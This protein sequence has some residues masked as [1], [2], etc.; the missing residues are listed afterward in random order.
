M[1]KISSIAASGLQ[2]KPN[3]ATYS[4]QE[5]FSLSTSR[6][7]NVEGQSFDIS[8]TSAN[9][10]DGRQKD[11]TITGVDSSD[12][13]NIDLSG[14]FVIENNID[15]TI[16]NTSVDASV[17]GVELFSLTL[18]DGSASV[19]VEI[20]DPTFTLSSDKSVVNEGESFTITLGTQGLS[21]GAQIAYTITGISSSDID[22]AALTGDFTINDNAASITFTVTDDGLSDPDETFLLSLDN[23]FDNISVIFREPTF[24]LSRSLSS[25]N[26]G[27]SFDITLT[28]TYI[29]DGTTFP[30]TVTGL[31]SADLTSGSITGNFVISSN[32]ATVSFIIAEDQLTE[33]VETF[34][35]SL[36]NG[37]ATIA[38]SIQ[39]TS[40][41]RTYALSSGVPTLNE[42]GVTT[43]TLETTNTP[44]GTLV[45]YTITG[46]SL[47]DIT[48]PSSLT[49]NFEI[50]N[51]IDAFN[52]FIR[53]DFL[54]EGPETIRIALDNDEAEV[55]I[56]IVDTSLTV[57]YQL[58]RS[59]TAVAEGGSFSIS[60][61]HSDI[62][63]GTVEP[64]TITGV[65]SAD[66]N[67]QSLTG[68]FT[69]NNNIA[70]V[71]FTVT[72][73][74]LTE[75]NET[76]TLTCDNIDIG[77][78]NLSISVTIVDTS[79]TPSYSLVATTGPVDEGD[80]IFVTLN[81]QNVASGTNIAYAVSGISADD[82]S[83]GSLSGNFNIQNN[84]ST[85][86]W[87]F[88]E[89]YATEGTETF[90]L[91]LTGIAGTPSV[92]VAIN[93]TT[94][95]GDLE[96]AVAS[97]TGFSQWYSISIDIS[98][99][100]FAV[101]D[102]GYNNGKGRVYMGR[103][104]D[105]TIFRTIDSPDIAGGTNRPAFGAG[106]TIQNNY[107]HV[108]SPTERSGP[109]GVP[110]DT[111]FV[112]VYTVPQGSRT[113]TLY[114]NYQSSPAGEEY[115]NSVSS[116]TNHVVIGM[117]GE[118][119]FDPTIG[120]F[121]DD[122]G[123][124]DIKTI[125][126]SN[127]SQVGHPIF[128]NQQNQ[129]FGTGVKISRSGNYFIATL[130]NISNTGLGGGGYTGRFFVYELGPPV[131]LLHQILNPQNS[132]LNSSNDNWFQRNVAINDTYFA[133]ACRSQNVSG[134]PGAGAVFLYN[135]SDGT[136]ART[137]TYQP[138]EQE[139]FG[140]CVDMNDDYI[141]IGH[142]G[143]NNTD[144]AVR[145]Y[146]L[147]DFSSVETLYHPDGTS[148]TGFGNVVRLTDTRLMTVSAN[149]DGV[150][151]FRI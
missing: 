62:P 123:R 31:N 67:G 128:S 137:F 100:Y 80:Q 63:N 94:Q 81:T 41:T 77:G 28:T 1:P 90:T 4:Y 140:S 70:T 134:Y 129:R 146:S 7:F 111:G 45:P 50:V 44:N 72:E 30:Y 46:I 66:I 135:I 114:A 24:I 99:D 71:N 147:S 10:P 82:L 36:D 40:L 33:G 107:M 85:L 53:E 93:D 75:G 149:G 6:D 130:P 14:T 84:I 132:S 5:L 98:Q 39:D 49:G 131:T 113:S 142:A 11:Y 52:L 68:N 19:V 101:P 95:F 151:I 17:E 104:S 65:S 108:G 25:V 105:G 112:F 18:D 48:S 2:S 69:I 76:L 106:V 150:W 121:R 42:G 64:Y 22:D 97:P 79:K 3:P 127:F 86:F 16:I 122:A 56:N 34:T 145:I 117:P 35:L 136:L 118:Q 15:T 27:G 119:A 92:S 96:Y 57:G 20:S 9:T 43:I 54:T 26:E 91:T 21:D 133:I 83:S 124:L 143:W 109:G 139:S 58:S 8:L 89:D 23:G 47:D 37:K 148:Q 12:I 73:D 74:A 87:T 120:G 116:S 60:L 38:V 126:G 32:T 88:D 144:G 125:T 13:D 110:A 141:A 55:F 103:L 138:I 115:G 61:T 102:S 51:N 78:S 59:T 29:T